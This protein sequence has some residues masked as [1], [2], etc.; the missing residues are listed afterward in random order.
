[1]EP[2]NFYYDP[3][4]SDYLDPRFTRHLDPAAV[5]MIFEIGSRDGHDAVLLQRRF[6][7]PVYAFECNPYALD[8][9]RAFLR[10]REGIVLIE[11]AAWNENTTLP[12]FPVIDTHRDGRRTLNQLGAASCL[13]ARPD[14]IEKYTQTEV[15]VEAIRLDDFCR[16]RGISGVD[17]LCMDVQGAAIP[18]LEGLGGI[19][20]TVRYLII[21]LEHRPIYQDQQ[22]F[23]E[24]RS[25]LSRRGLILVE[26]TFQN[27][28][29]SNFLFIRR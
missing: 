22:L 29:Y 10:D 19:L 12:F 13:R 8:E 15:T 28:W 14:Y 18:V 11:K 2:R 23:P 5:G 1:M 20:D 4:F 21:E 6:Q 7:A 3:N 27:D 9:C 25:Y 24:V 16:D 17:F 26:E